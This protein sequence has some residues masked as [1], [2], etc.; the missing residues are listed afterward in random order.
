MINPSNDKV[1]AVTFMSYNPTGL[2]SSVKCRFSNKICDELDVDFFAVQE[3]FKFVKTTDQFFRK[4]FPNYFTYLLPGYRSPGQEHGRAKAGLAQLTKKSLKIKK[5]RIETKGFRIQCQVLHLPSTRVLWINSYLPT[6]P[7]TIGEYD[8]TE[9]RNVLVEVE[10]IIENNNFDDIVWGSDLNWDPSRNSHFSRTMQSFVQKLGLVSLWSSNPVPYTHMH[11]DGKSSSTI[12]HFLLTPRLV[13]L[14]EDCGVIERGDNLSRH[15]P[16]WVKLRLGTLPLRKQSRIWV[17]KRIGWSKSTEAERFNYTSDLQARLLALKLPDTI[18][19]ADPHCRDPSHLQ[20]RDGLVLDILEGIVQSSYDTLPTHGGRWV[21]GKG[22]RQ[23]IAVPG[24]VAEVE[25]ARLESIY[26]GDVWLKEGRPSTGWLHDLY[27]RKRAQ[28]HYA[29]RKA[30]ANSKKHRAENL[31]I[32]ALEGDTALLKEM[33][34]VKKGGGGPAELPDTVGGANGEAEIVDKFK[35]IYSALYNSAATEAEMATLFRKV[36]QLISPDSLAEVSRLNGG[37]VKLAVSKLR[38]QKSD[39]S[40]QFTSDALLHAPDILFHQLAAVFR[41]WLTH[42]NITPS[43]LACSFLPLLKSSLKDPANPASYRAIAGSSLILK[44]FENVVLLLWGH[45]LSS[46]S[47]QFGFKAG[48]STTQCTWMVSEVVQHLL[49]NGT[50]P[51]VTVLDCTKAFDLCKFSLLFQK[52]LDSGLPPI[53]VRCL[54]MMYQEQ[55]G[56]V[57]WGQARSEKFPI[58]NGT[59]QGA[60]LSPAFWAVYCDGMIQ[61]LRELGVGAH[62]GGKF[63]GIACYADDVVLVAPCHQAMQMMLG[64]VENFANKYNIS[65]STDPDPAKS[66]SKCIYMIGRRH[67]LSKPPPLRLSGRNLPWVESATHLGHELHQSGTMDQDTLIKRAMF[68]R[69]S[70]E[71]RTMFKFASPPEILKAL[72]IYCSSFYGCM[73]WDL[74]G[75]KA[76]QVYNSWNMAVKLTWNCPRQTKTFLVQQ[77]LSHGMSSARTDI[78]A[79]YVTFFKGLRT[80]PSPEIRTLAYLMGRDILSTTGKNL[81]TIREASGLD[82]WQASSASMKDALQTNELVEILP[83]DRWRVAYLHSL[84]RQHQEALTM[85][86]EFTV[87]QIQNLIESL[88]I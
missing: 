7:Q 36:G 3:H 88:V 50:N 20:D 9:L 84:L 59:R 51:I 1:T 58:C 63:M 28:Y 75:D 42:G 41:S 56:W 45:L 73:L 11:T 48:T 29:V 18:W 32:A 43:L 82:P 2:D 68:I 54:M 79:R 44:V 57:K 16:I 4:Q 6:D 12:D 71:V 23:G 65:F 40:T 10:N 24:W 61:E 14:V 8:D 19:C 83:Q 35:T 55:H 38:P 30:K 87:T 25:P 81:K 27:C 46:D 49:R 22:K 13:P 60:I 62:V 5:E 17:P 33:K 66:K 86:L 70:V 69:D 72:K 80:S 47:L 77:V 26:W 52:L 31:L 74:A 21:S 15:C 37:V 85:T 78:L 39:V 34:V 67:A 76:T 53:V 64:V